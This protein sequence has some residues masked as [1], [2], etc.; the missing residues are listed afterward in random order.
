[1]LV[2]TGACACMC[3]K[4]TQHMTAWSHT[5]AVCVTC[6]VIRHRSNRSILKLKR[7]WKWSKKTLKQLQLFWNHKPTINPTIVSLQLKRAY[8]LT[9]TCSMIWQKKWLTQYVR[10]LHHYHRWSLLI[11][12]FVK[13]TLHTQ[14]NHFYLF[15]ITYHNTDRI[16]RQSHRQSIP[17][18]YRGLIYTRKSPLLLSMCIYTMFV[19]TCKHWSTVQPY[20]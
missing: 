16:H 18:R 11:F 14:L 9:F 7:I 15:P 10:L 4:I 20:S 6:N 5:K 8:K 19:S 3:I 2:C 1:M 17:D 12:W 13:F